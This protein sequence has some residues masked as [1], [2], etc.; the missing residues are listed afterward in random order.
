M[1]RLIHMVKAITLNTE[2]LHPHAEPPWWR[3]EYDQDLHKWVHLYVPE[4]KE[5]MSVKLEWAEDHTSLYDEYKDDS[6]YMF[7]YTDSS[8]SY[9]KG[10]HRTGYGVVA[11]R[12]GMEIASEQGP[13]G[14]YIEAYDTEMK[15][16][17]V[18]AKMIQELV[19]SETDSPPLKI[20]IAT[21]NM[22][23]LQ[24]IFQ[25]SP[26][27][28]QSCLPPSGATYLTYLTSMKTSNLP[29]LGAQVTLTL[30]EMNKL[31]V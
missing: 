26:G 25:G 4:N 15:A 18:A 10:S 17:E 9:D 16:L 5:G 12:N 23:A 11:Y 30:K 27:K 2:H 6:E 19:H 31:T 1:T 21:N 28:A 24:C 14:E 22:G 13:L 20:I 7:I 3:S 8:L 29:L